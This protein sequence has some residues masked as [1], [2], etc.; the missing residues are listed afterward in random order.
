MCRLGQVYAMTVQSVKIC[1]LVGGFRKSLAVELET[2][3][4][5]TMEIESRKTLL[6]GLGVQD[7]DLHRIQSYLSLLWLSNEE[8]NL[9]SRKMT[10]DELLDNH[11]VDC[12]LPLKYFPQDIKSVADFGSGGGLPGVLFALLFPNVTFHLFEKSPKKQEFL[13]KCH[14]LVPNIIVHGDIPADLDAI[15]L[16]IAR[17]FKPLDVLL[18][19]SRSYYQKSGR[20]F[21]LKGRLIKIEEEIA[22]ARKKFNDLKVEVL[23]LQSPVLEV[24]RHLVM[25]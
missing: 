10:V 2:M 6:K 11:L 16:V 3:K 14:S 5:A 25:I 22:L 15:E 4:M 24:E 23:P 18:E 21:L 9:F 19:M 12:L 1:K 8:L 17:A 7:A 20:Y 13:K